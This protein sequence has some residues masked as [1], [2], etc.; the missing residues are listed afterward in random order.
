VISN[1]CDQSVVNTVVISNGCD[2]Q[3]QDFGYRTG[4]GKKYT[5]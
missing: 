1:G 4:A 2:Q 5:F 3:V